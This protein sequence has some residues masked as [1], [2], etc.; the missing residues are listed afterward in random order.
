[1]S[2]LSAAPRRGVAAR[3]TREVQGEVEDVAAPPEDDSEKDP[4]GDFTD[5]VPDPAGSKRGLRVVEDDAWGAVVPAVLFVDHGFYRLDL[6]WR[7]DVQQACRACAYYLSPPG[8]SV[9]QAGG[10]PG[11]QAARAQQ[12]RPAAA[13]VRDVADP[14]RAEQPGQ[15]RPGRGDQR[16]RI[17]RIYRVHVSPRMVRSRSPGWDV[18][19]LPQLRQ[20][21]QSRDAGKEEVGASSCPHELGYAAVTTA[22]RALRN[23]KGRA[24][25]LAGAGER[26]SVVVESAERGV[27]QPGVLDEFEL[28]GQVGRQAQEIKPGFGTPVPGRLVAA[29][30][31]QEAVQIAGVKRA[32]GV[33][34]QRV[35]R[36]R[37]ADVRA[38]GAD[39]P[40]RVGLI[41]KAVIVAERRYVL[42][43][44]V[45]QGRAAWPSAYHL[46]GQRDPP[47][48][49]FGS[50]GLPGDLVKEP[51]E[52]VDVLFKLTK[53]EIG[54]V[55]PQVSRA[56]TGRVGKQQAFGVVGRRQ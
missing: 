51:P 43:R 45:D 8:E 54:A 2:V 14:P 19:G 11:G 35:A 10:H 21:A 9:G 22:H 25:G 39:E 50:V 23:G 56:A 24:C 49:I 7:Q 3:S 1:M 26:V 32:G 5:L 55:S 4:G 13:A 18:I 53:D 27:V 46:R 20:V 40:E 33:R 28:P 44:C 41:A 34:G 16:G 29:P 17:G 30:T 37:P 38:D 48:W 31:A 6:Q 42:V 15:L 47:V 36:V 52:P 12:N